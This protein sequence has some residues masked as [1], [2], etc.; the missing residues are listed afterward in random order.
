M[1][2]T[3]H[4]PVYLPWLGLFHKIALADQFCV[5]D[6]AQYQ[7]KDFNNRN[8]IKTNTG[9]IWLSVPVESKDHFNKP[10]CNVKIINN[11]WNRK[12]IKSISLAYKKAAYYEQYFPALEA[13]LS[14]EFELLSDLNTRMLELLLEQ[15]GIRVPVT[16]ATTYNLQG[17]KS[18]LVLDMCLKLGASDYV[19]GAQGRDYADVQSFLAKGVTPY[20][21]SYVHPQY[22]QLHGAFEP[23]MSVIDLLYNEGPRSHE[24]LVSGNIT[25]L[26]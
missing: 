6:V 1:I 21:Q 12:H 5:F 19:F 16:M 24:I 8:K 7:T 26:R 4:Q 3:A 15:L 13:I 18:D 23:Y 10:I 11:G 9:P 22:Q 25:A 2:L 14:N 17:A 20:F